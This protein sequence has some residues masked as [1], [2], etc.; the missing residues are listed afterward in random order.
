MAVC[1]RMCSST[2]R[3]DREQQSDKREGRW[4]DCR[5]PP[6]SC[7][8]RG[9]FGAQG[10]PSKNRHHTAVCRCR[11]HHRI[12]G[13]ERTSLR[14]HHSNASAPGLSQLLQNFLGF[15][16]LGSTAAAE[17][18]A[19][20]DMPSTESK[21]QS[22]SSQHQCHCQH[23]KTRQRAQQDIRLVVLA[24]RHQLRQAGSTTRVH[25]LVASDVRGSSLR[26][27]AL[28]SICAALNW[29]LH[30]NLYMLSEVLGLR[31]IAGGSTMAW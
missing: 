16:T 23:P 21:S 24:S 6:A 10:A 9:R 19:A 14:K 29:R 22:V 27:S 31:G 12:S 26:R 3:N 4:R 13:R 5:I 28:V 15:I 11:Q 25:H 17:L 8:H 30:W 20:P 18:F 7:Q 2:L 1:P